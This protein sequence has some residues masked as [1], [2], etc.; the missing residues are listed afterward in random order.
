MKIFTKILGLIL[1][2]FISGCDKEG[3]KLDR[4]TLTGKWKM[5]ATYADIGNGAGQWE[6][7]RKNLLLYV[8]FNADG[9][10]AGN[11]FPNYVR[12]SVTDSSTLR[13]ESNDKA[14][15]NY[16]YKLEDGNLIMSPAGPIYCTEGCGSKFQK[17]Q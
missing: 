3:V 17:V 1:L 11:A 5:T 6:A 12:Y 4:S 7:A 2:I 9:S 15:Q 8:T 10:V 16:A 14:I 13:F